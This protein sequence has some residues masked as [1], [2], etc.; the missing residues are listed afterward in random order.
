MG[1]WN[2]PEILCALDK[3]YKII[4]IYEVWHWS[5]RGSIFTPYVNSAIKEKQEASGFPDWCK[6][7]ED[8]REYIKLYYEK[9]GIQLDYDNINFN[10]G[11]RAVA[12]IKANSQWGYLGMQSNKTKHK[13]F[14]VKKRVNI[15]VN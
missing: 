9:E 10:S 7:E 5:E 1:T 2:T 4:T 13:F 15:D 11:A 3:G 8:K 14:K 12:K 6:S